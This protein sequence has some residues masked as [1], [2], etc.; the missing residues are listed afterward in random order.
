MTNEDREPTDAELK[1]LE[2]QGDNFDLFTDE[3]LMWLADFEDEL[4]PWEPN[5]IPFSHLGIDPNDVIDG[6]FPDEQEV[7]RYAERNLDRYD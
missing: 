6:T 1:A 5:E 4:D 2:D 3:D 7:R